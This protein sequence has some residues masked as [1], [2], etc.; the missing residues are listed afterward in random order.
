M[1]A[2]LPT[3]AIKPPQERQWGNKTSLANNKNLQAPS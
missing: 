3:V 2:S 1:I